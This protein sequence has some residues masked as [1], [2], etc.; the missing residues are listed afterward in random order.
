ML[1]SSI[2]RSWMSSSLSNVE[3]GM[4]CRNRGGRGGG[5]KDRRIEDRGEEESS[6]GEKEVQL[7]K[8]DGM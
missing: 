1:T 2:R 7:E 4:V 3:Y 6:D 8:G 5:M